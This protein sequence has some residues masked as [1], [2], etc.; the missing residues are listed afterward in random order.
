[1]SKRPYS[2][3]SYETYD[4]FFRELAG[5]V[6]TNFRFKHT[7]Y[8]QAYALENLDALEDPTE[9]LRYC[10]QQSIDRT[11]AKSREAGI[12]A[13]RIDLIISSPLLSSDIYLPIRPINENTVD[14]LLN[15]FLKTMQSHT[16]SNIYGEPFNVTVTGIKSSALPRQ[17]TTI[18]RGRRRF[19]Q[20]IRRDIKEACIIEIR[21][22]DQ[23]CLF[24]AL[25]LM[26]IHI[27][28]EM[29]HQSFL[30]YKQNI[31]NAQ[32]L[33]KRCAKPKSLFIFLSTSSRSG[34]LLF[35]LIMTKPMVQVSEYF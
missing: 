5:G 18:G 15:M 29:T 33:Y 35:K 13:D 7:R 4:D 26:R 23:Y 2:K 22:N 20:K 28:K 9:V 3:I 27:S 14:A 11:M 32:M 12:E 1:M 34:A 30:R 19:A 17:R 25:E 21:N 31:D 6:K 24:Y 10:F 8:T 16:D